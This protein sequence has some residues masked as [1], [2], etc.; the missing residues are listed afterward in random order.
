MNTRA[1]PFQTKLSSSH[2]QVKSVVY[3]EVHT[4]RLP[5]RRSQQRR[6]GLSGS[7][8]GKVL[9]GQRQ[10]QRED[11]R[12]GGWET[13]WRWRHVWDVRKRK[14]RRQNLGRSRSETN[15]VLIT[16]CHQF[17]DRRQLTDS[18]AACHMSAPP[19]L[20]ANVR[21]F[22]DMNCAWWELKDN[23]GYK[24]M[25]RTRWVRRQKLLLLDG[26]ITFLFLIRTDS[27]RVHGSELLSPLSNLNN[28]KSNTH[29]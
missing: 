25:A 6:V 3:E 23:E 20:R 10:G 22:A 11:A 16:R 1:R 7:M 24:C 19:I 8:R 5:R 29:M 15:A 14:K 26:L 9:R 12:R 27:Y 4:C 13:G 2:S 28:H 21:A 17:L 18:S